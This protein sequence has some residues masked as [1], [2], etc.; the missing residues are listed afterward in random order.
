MII[1][2]RDGFITLASISMFMD[3]EVRFRGVAPY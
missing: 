3:M 2:T 1:V